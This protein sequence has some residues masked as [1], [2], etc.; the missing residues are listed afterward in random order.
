MSPYLK[1]PGKVSRQRG[2][3]LLV[4]LVMLML[5]LVLAVIGMRVVTLESRITGNSLLNQRMFEVAD[6]TLREGER[7]LL[8]HATALQPCGGASAIMNSGIPCYV[9]EARTD[10]LGMNTNFGAANAILEAAVGFQTTEDPSKQPA[11]AGYW[12]PRYIDTV[13]PKGESATSALNAAVVGC[14]EYHE[15]NSQAARVDQD[16]TSA[17]KDCGPLAYCLRSTVNMF[18]K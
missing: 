14:T 8:N 5:I 4:S 11:L 17:P 13:C 10:A 9:S 16:A 18:I 15:M 3:A 1:F 6:G 2:A 12:Y 7:Q